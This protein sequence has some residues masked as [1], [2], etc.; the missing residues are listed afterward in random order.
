VKQGVESYAHRHAISVV[1]LD[2]MTNALAGSQRA[3][4]G[5]KMPFFLKQA[6]SRGKP[7]ADD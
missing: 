6:G 2:T 4:R 7:P 5:G 3:K 1:S